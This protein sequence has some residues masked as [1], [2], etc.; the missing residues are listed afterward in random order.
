M[1]DPEARRSR[2][3]DPSDAESEEQKESGFIMQGASSRRK[4]RVHLTGANRER[5]GSA[6]TSPWK[7]M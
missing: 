5:K 2:S 4:Q 1:K 7:T 6:L 3:F